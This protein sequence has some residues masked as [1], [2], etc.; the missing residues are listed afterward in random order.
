MNRWTAVAL[1]A[2]AVA[3]APWVAR[4]GGLMDQVAAAYGTLRTYHAETQAVGRMMER[5]GQVVPQLQLRARLALDR[6]GGRLRLTV[7]RGAADA[8]EPG[9]GWTLV[10]TAAGRVLAQARQ[11]SV[12]HRSP[13]ERVRVVHNVHCELDPQVL[14]SA[15]LVGHLLADTPAGLP[16]VAL[17]LSESPRHGLALLS[18]G[19]ILGAGPIQTPESAW[20][21]MLRGPQR[22]AFLDL[23]PAS[24]LIRGMSVTPTDTAE[25]DGFVRWD[26][27]LSNV[28]ADGPLD[29]DWFQLDLTGSEP[30]SPAVV[31]G[32]PPA[33]LLEGRPAPPAR[34]PIAR[35]R[36]V[37]LDQVGP[38]PLVL[39]YWNVAS[40]GTAEGLA[41][42]HELARWSDHHGGPEVV[43]VNL[44]DTVEQVVQF[45][46]Q[47]NVSLPLVADPQGLLAQPL[48]VT[49]APTAIMIHQGRV[50]LVQ[51]GHR[52][53]LAQML[54]S[55]LRELTD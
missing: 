46:Q 25:F 52:P 5:H 15:R 47:H 38:R 45:K 53:D 17:L 28:A 4:A 19:T 29:P 51:V 22:T 13:T 12:M 14:L 54:Q 11:I 20:R 37:Q 36:W 41:A 6:P 7:E 39:Y 10:R 35:N 9:P 1:A 16:D 44:G 33:Y 49:G 3:L 50:I 21:L 43:A 42:L 48:Q 31:L 32:L 8:A 27:T 34:L 30:A 40:A 23:E 2:L 55:R 24:R 26:Y 18:G